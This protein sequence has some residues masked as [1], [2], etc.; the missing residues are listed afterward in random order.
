M[1]YSK[2]VPKRASWILVC[3]AWDCLSGCLESIMIQR[4]KSSDTVFID[5]NS[6]LS[7][8]KFFWSC[9]HVNTCSKLYIIY[10][11]P[12]SIEYFMQGNFKYPRIK[13]IHQILEKITRCDQKVKIVCALLLH[14]LLSTK[15]HYTSIYIFYIL[16]ISRQVQKSKNYEN[17]T[18]TS[19]VIK[20]T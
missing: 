6:I 13:K 7:K 10:Q 16:F 9:T 2:S 20:K 14:E 3:P 5:C 15:L 1:T 18:S 12:Y 19:K 4:N 8:S 11:S 17:P